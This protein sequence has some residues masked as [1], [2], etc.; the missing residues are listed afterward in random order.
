MTGSVIGL[1]AGVLVKCALFAFLVRQV[2]WL[3]AAYFMFIANIITSL[4]GMVLVGA[5]TAMKTYADER[6]EFRRRKL[7]DYLR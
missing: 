5:S 7:A 6:Y 3:K 2:S 1:I 4:F